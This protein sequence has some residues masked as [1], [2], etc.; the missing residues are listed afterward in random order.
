MITVFGRSMAIGI[1]HTN[2][3]SFARYVCS[4]DQN[5]YMDP[6]AN[7]HKGWLQLMLTSVTYIR[8]AQKHWW[9]V[10]QVQYMLGLFPVLPYLLA[11]KPA[12]L[13]AATEPRPLSGRVGIWQTC[14]SPEWYHTGWY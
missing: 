5:G 12:W 2:C 14:I 9:C 13:R 4:L 6:D 8:P 10:G 11:A 3:L 1:C 7:W